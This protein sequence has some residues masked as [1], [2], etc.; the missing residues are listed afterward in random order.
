MKFPDIVTFKPLRRG[1]RDRIDALRQALEIRGGYGKAPT[2][3]QAGTCRVNALVIRNGNRAL[4]HRDFRNIVNLFVIRVN[5]RVIEA[6]A[7][8]YGEGYEAACEYLAVHAPPAAVKTNA[9]AQD[10]VNARTR[11]I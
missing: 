10:L 4:L 5:K 11:P 6:D 9:S 2:Q 7:E 3:L 1:K 8:N